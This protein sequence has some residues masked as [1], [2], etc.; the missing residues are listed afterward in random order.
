MIVP[1]QYD[2]NVNNFLNKGKTKK[3]FLIQITKFYHDLKI[4]LKKNC[5]D[6]C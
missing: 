5:Y 1:V 4:K 6:Y 3:H 2:L